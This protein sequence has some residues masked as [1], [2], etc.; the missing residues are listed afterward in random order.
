MFCTND[1]GMLFGA[2][3]LGCKLFSFSFIKDAM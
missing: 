2:G 1:I 3:V